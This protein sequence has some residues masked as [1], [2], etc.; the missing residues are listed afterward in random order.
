MSYL[1]I[2]L[3]ASARAEE[4][5][6]DHLTTSDGLSE[7][8]IYC[9]LQDSKGYI[10][11]GTHDGLNRYD[12]YSFTV[13]K[14]IPYD[15]LS[16]NNNQITALF[17]DRRGTL[18]VGTQ[19]GLHR[20][21]RHTET[22]ERILPE[23]NNPTSISG[24]GI[25]AICED[26]AGNIWI[27]ADNGLNVL[28]AA[29]L[30]T[31]SSR[32]LLFHHV[33]QALFKDTYHQNFFVRSVYC[34]S[35]GTMWLGTRYAL[36]YFREEDTSA[37]LVFQGSSEVTA[38]CERTRGKVWFGTLDGLYE[39]D[40]ALHRYS[41]I[42]E[43]TSQLFHDKGVRSIIR[44]SDGNFWIATFAG[45]YKRD[46]Q[47]NSFRVFTNEPG[48]IRTLSNNRVYSLCL[49]KSGV[50]WIGTFGKGIDRVNLARKKF[51]HYLHHGENISDQRDNMVMA[52]LEDRFGKIWLGT[53]E[54]NIAVFDRYANRWLHLKSS[55]SSAY[56]LCEDNAGTIWIGDGVWLSKYVERQE[57]IVA[58]LPGEVLSLVYDAPFLWFGQA[59]I[60]KQL[61][62][63]TM[64]EASYPF[65][66]ALFPS[67]AA[68]QISQEKNIW[69]AAGK[70]Y[71][72]NLSTKQMK[73]YS[74]DPHNA[75][76]ISSNNII[77]LCV[78]RT[79]ALW[80]GTNGG[81]LN[82]FNKEN[83]TF[84]HYFERD[85]LPN[86][87]I[88]GIL[89]DEK[90]NLWISTNR[91]ISRFDPKKGAFRNFDVDDGL[92]AN[93]FNRGACFKNKKG[94]M[95]FGG[96]NGFNSFFPNEI[97]DNPHIPSIVLTDVRV[98][99]ERRK[100]TTSYPELKEIRLSYDENFFSFEFAA[101]DF[102]NPS[103]NKYAYMLE[104]FD[105]DWVK[106]GSRH[107][108][109]YTDVHPGEYLFRVRGSNSDDVWNN[110]G[111]FI[112]V[113]IIPPYWA[114]WWFRSIATI[115]LLSIG[116]IL[117]FRR[118]NKLE[119]E[120]KIRE[121]FSRQLI[122]SQE[123]ERKRIAAALHDSLAQNLIISKN[124]AAL[125]LKNVRGESNLEHLTEIS[126]LL[127]QSL[128]EVREIAY[129]LRPYHLDR[130][131]LTRTLEYLIYKVKSS[132]TIE[133]HTEIENIDKRLSPESE[134]N[135]YRIV[136]EA[137]NNVVK[138]SEATRLQL[139]VQRIDRRIEIK[140]E[141][142]GKGFDR[143]STTPAAETN[144]GFGLTGIAERVRL[145][146]GT[147]TIHTQ[148]GNGTTITIT[149]PNETEKQ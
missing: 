53:W 77:S 3:L 120:K 88:Y 141:D 35:S 78:A 90:G 116:P 11:F 70:L 118:V 143:Q 142:N 140:I 68:I 82:R 61:H 31:A 131:G 37:T 5:K 48:D 39:Y 44:D 52:L 22:F 112:A 59:G 24:I 97:Q 66:S 41:A 147:F 17:E 28:R 16:L 54:N 55:N 128:D 86:N 26:K 80:I 121:A 105:N 145:L 75:S 23:H 50:L 133:C 19:N 79:G 32:K 135:L 109:N 74:H 29:T 144:G 73:A 110:D 1:T 7:G 62:V 10:W 21:N 25:E 83:E 4:L 106:A 125:G 34:D 30:Q 18:W 69:F 56:A 103:K 108:A 12:G 98:L 38:I 137:F 36:Y 115:G 96:V 65:D 15:S 119:R 107:I 146:R 51:H 93:E 132:T 91:G 67:I 47:T 104:G 13:F 138:H 129:N 113:T 149:I 60:L 72:F 127:T 6:F 117:Y 45:L 134:I 94:E 57:R 89:E 124:H 100:F 87:V 101:L 111:L 148:E 123:N 122:E 95:F 114:T 85:G 130:I 64:Q 40:A 46:V 99:N 71:Q 33:E 81:G 139:S 92:Q 8:V 49:D 63:Q 102:T 14:N 136:Q 76:S 9:I 43:I 84:T 126:S 42:S 58:Q 20:F 2:G 27:G